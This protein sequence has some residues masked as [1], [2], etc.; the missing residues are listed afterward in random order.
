MDPF[1]TIPEQLSV[2]E[3]ALRGPQWDAETLDNLRALMARVDS[4]RLDALRTEHAEAMRT[5]DPASGYKYLDVAY[6]TLLKLLLAREL[7]LDRGPPRRILD[8]GT[9]GGHF[10]FV[11]RHF[12]H[13]VVAID[14]ENP[15]YEGITACL[16]VQ[17][18]IARVEPYRPLP[19]LGGRFDLITVCNTTFNERGDPPVYWTPAEW[20]FLLDDLVANHLRYPGELYVKLNKEIKRLAYNRDVL[21][22][23]NRNAAKVGR[24]RGVIRMNVAAPRVIRL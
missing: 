7:G 17:R 2:L 12:G 13:D 11:C 23:A 15:L 16:G 1:K 6:F 9:A 24:W 8:I 4:A 18:T 21:A 14:V 10:P 3:K 5:A 20:Q 22:M 19:D